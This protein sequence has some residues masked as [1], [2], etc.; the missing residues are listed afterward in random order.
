[1]LITEFQSTVSEYWVGSIIV[2]VFSAVFYFI[3]ASL[4]NEDSNIRIV[5]FFRHS[6]YINTFK[7]LA[8]QFLSIFDQI[9]LSEKQQKARPER[10]VSWSYGLLN[11]S[12][13]ITLLY[14]FSFIHLQWVIFGGS[15]G[16][17]GFEITMASASFLQRSF[18]TI[19]FF[20]C[21]AIYFVWGGKK[22]YSA[23]IFGVIMTCISCFIFFQNVS[24]NYITDLQISFFVSIIFSIIFIFFMTFFGEFNVSKLASLYFII[25]TLVLLLPVFGAIALIFFIYFE[26]HAMDEYTSQDDFGFPNLDIKEFSIELYL[27]RSAIF[28]GFIVMV[29]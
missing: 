27:L 4:K 23:V 14:S 24:G 26:F 3:G 11:W 16:V 25:C 8:L 18:S 22:N 9:I 17:P 13:L 5:N 20:L 28:Y 12:I 7:I 19:V 1:M 10:R 15:V 29:S 2:F 6:Q 21:L